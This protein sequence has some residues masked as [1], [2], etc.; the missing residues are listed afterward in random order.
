MELRNRSVI[1]WIGALILFFL[2]I[3]FLIF[4][5]N[6]IGAFLFINALIIAL[7]AVIEYAVIKKRQA[8]YENTEEYS[9]KKMEE[10]EL[11][12]KRKEREK[13][14]IMLYEENVKKCGFKDSEKYI[15]NR[16]HE[17]IWVS[18]E[19]D[20]IFIPSK[21]DVLFD[22]RSY[23]D[24]GGQI[25]ENYYVAKIA[26]SNIVYYEKIGDVQYTAQVNATGG[27]S[28]IKGA[29]IGGVI[30][31]GAGAIIGSRNKINVKTSTQ[32]HDTRETVIYYE[33]E[34]GAVYSYSL[35]GF[36]LYDYLLQRIPEKDMKYMNLIHNKRNNTVEIL[37]I[38]KR[39]EK[40]KNL[41]ENGLISESEYEDKRKSI[42]E[43]I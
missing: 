38:E 41:L 35:P 20:I 13:S 1:W 9:K 27:G 22:N 36:N 12:E 25:V 19:K 29:V 33:K 32:T 24:D 14:L 31:G 23:I 4:G 3:I 6:E 15:Q 37:N 11:D 17:I 42:L 28:S 40:L 39:L 5:S 34:D 16:A 10:K 43:N 18:R 21:Q 2:S 8:E 26:Y 7:V 30:A